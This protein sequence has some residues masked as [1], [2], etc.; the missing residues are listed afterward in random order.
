M[1]NREKR[2]SNMKNILVIIMLTLLMGCNTSKNV[3]KS[4][5]SSPNATITKEINQDALKIRNYLSKDIV[6]AHRGSTY[7]A[8]EQTEPAYRWARNIGA[9]YLELDLQMT[10]DSIL[11][12]VHDETLLRTSN[13]KE[14]FPE[15]IEPTT[16][17]FTLKELRSLDFGTWFNKLNPDRAKDTYKSLK[18]LTFQ[19]VVM[20][21]EGYR[22][23]K[24]DGECSKE[25][26][27]NNGTGKYL[28]E[29]D[30]SDNKNRPGIYAETKKLHLEQLL[31]KEIKEYKWL[32]TDNPKKI[33]TYK[34]KVA[35]ANTDARFILQT[36]YR[37]SIEEL[38]MVLPK[39]PK[40]LLLW[41]PDMIGDL[42]S[43]FIDAINFCA[44]NNVEIIGTSIS[45]KP[46]N[47]DELTDKWMVDLIHKS[48]III[49]PYTFDTNDDF[50]RYSND[51]DGVFTNRADLALIFYKR[52]KN[53]NSEKILKD[54]GY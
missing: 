13:V 46:N 12:V 3:M 50:T 49:H 16:N 48:G 14:V 24:E 54:L 53:N 7:W 8:P 40:C 22:I 27:N 9:D 15:V 41:K 32:I 4:P 33:K 44:D 43:N 20:I 11:V 5:F 36:F 2:K 51:V 29:L 10:K 30:P 19:D 34:D 23:K 28:Y 35:I 25:I 1:A 39:V 17:D 42:D 37:S 47:Y 52:L 6:I 31:A 38:E 18:I 26:I 45:G 21:A